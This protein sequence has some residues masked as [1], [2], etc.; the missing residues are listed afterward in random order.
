MGKKN[1]LGVFLHTARELKQLSLRG[2]EK[3]IGVSNAYL[4]QIESGKISQPSPNILHKLCELYEISYSDV[5]RLAGY[6]IP[7]DN[8]ERETKSGLPSSVGSITEEEEQALIEYLA[9]LR[10]R[11]SR[12]E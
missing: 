4:S 3:A 12:K 5:L 6:P 8:D 7:D 10:S 11:R 2:V 1:D 9:F